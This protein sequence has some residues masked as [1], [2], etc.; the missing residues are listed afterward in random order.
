MN[1]LTVKQEKFAQKYVELGN[2]SE[3]YRQSYAAENM[4]TETIHVAASQLLDNNKVA[5]RV[6]ELQEELK[7]RHDITLDYITEGLEYAV[8]V[9][10]I[11]QDAS[12]IR[13]GYMDLAKLYGLAVEK[14]DLTSGGNEIQSVVIL[15]SKNE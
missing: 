11:K 8:N 4:A 10:K 9:A 5:I 14:V 12:N 15:P 2:A 3:A 13:G 6:K 1:N 7:S